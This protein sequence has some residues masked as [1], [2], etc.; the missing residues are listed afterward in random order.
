MGKRNTMIRN[1]R[2]VFLTLVRGT[3]IESLRIDVLLLFAGAVFLSSL[4][5][6]ELLM[7]PITGILYALGGTVPGSKDYFLVSQQMIP[8]LIVLLAYGR[9]LSNELNFR[10][11]IVLPKCQSRSIW[12]FSLLTGSMGISFVFSLIGTGMAS[13]GG[14]LFQKSFYGLGW[15]NPVFCISLTEFVKSATTLE[16]VSN[17]LLVFILFFIRLFMLLTIQLVVW[18]VSAK[19]SVPLFTAVFMLGASLIYPQFLFLP[20]GGTMF[21]VTAEYGSFHGA[22]I[23]ISLVFLI[24]IAAFG[25]QYTSKADWIKNFDH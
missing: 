1:K 18:I 23:L 19:A 8:I 5:S 14:L 17:A 24:V 12:F 6:R 22:G 20:V 4:A 2:G 15:I 10:C 7:T 11:Q 9:I 21:F 3:M 16:T 25:W 13:L